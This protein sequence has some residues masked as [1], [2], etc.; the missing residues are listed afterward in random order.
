[1][2]Y[3]LLPDTY[4][5]FPPQS[6]ANLEFITISRAL[7]KLTPSLCQDLLRAEQFAFSASLDV[8]SAL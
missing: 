8:S 2:L 1:M 7:N 3:L 4:A 6:Q 5:P